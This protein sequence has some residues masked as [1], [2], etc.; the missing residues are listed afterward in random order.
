MGLFLRWFHQQGPVKKTKFMTENLENGYKVWDRQKEQIKSVEA[1]G[2]LRP[3]PR[4][5]LEEPGKSG[6]PYA[7]REVV[8]AARTRTAKEMHPVLETQPQTERAGKDTPW[9]LFPFTLR[10]HLSSAKPRLEPDG[11]GAQEM[12]F[13]K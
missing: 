7:L 5:R 12:S 4:L 2:R 13:V 9:L 10:S 6:G 1:V 11:K 8:A 3:R